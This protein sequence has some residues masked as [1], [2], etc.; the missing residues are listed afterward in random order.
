MPRRRSK[1]E[2]FFDVVQACQGVRISQLMY[3]SGVN[4]DTLKKKILPVLIKQGLIKVEAHKKRKQRIPH[5]VYVK[6]E[7]GIKFLNLMREM[8]QMLG[9]APRG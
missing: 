9:D 6:T 7:L 4:M 8:Q 1:L 5:P 3:K 2:I